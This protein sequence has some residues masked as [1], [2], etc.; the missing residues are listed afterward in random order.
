[1]ADEEAQE[2]DTPTE[3]TQELD[4]EDSAADIDESTDSEVVKT[5]TD[6]ESADEEIISKGDLRIPLKEERQRRRELEERLAELESQVQNQPFVPQKASEFGPQ[7]VGGQETMQQEIAKQANLVYQANEA[8]KQYPQLESDNALAAAVW[9]EFNRIGGKENL[10]KVAGK[11]IDRF[12]K[13]GAEK[14]EKKALL[15]QGMRGISKATPSGKSASAVPKT[16]TREW[17]AS[18]SDDGY[19]KHEKEINE[20]LSQGLIE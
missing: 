12:T 11:V 14:G 3:E 1:M 10:A 15:D 19:A 7:E 5:D 18:L 9:Y 4:V 8:I 6:S 17:I 13:L 16:I 2:K 20:A